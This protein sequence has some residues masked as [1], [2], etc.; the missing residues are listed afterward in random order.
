LSFSAAR[1]NSMQLPKEIAL[2]LLIANL[3]ASGTANLNVN[4]SGAMLAHSGTTWLY[5][6]N[7]TTPL[8]T[9]LASGL[10]SAFALSVQFQSILAVLIDAAPNL[11]GDFNRDGMVDGA[12]YITWRQT[13]TQ[14]VPNGSGADADGNGMIDQA[15]YDLWRS[16]FGTT[17]LSSAAS[18]LQF[19]VPEPNVGTLSLVAAIGICVVGSRRDLSRSGV[20]AGH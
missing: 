14:T 15:D 3:N 8:Q 18:E 5:G 17:G 2:G 9:S 1:L 11:I 4:I 20:I 10:G 6:V 7:Q 12:D 16:N 19:A 13:V